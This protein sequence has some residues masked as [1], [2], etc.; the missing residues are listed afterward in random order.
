[1][2]MSCSSAATCS[3]SRSRPERPWSSRHSSNRP[4]REHRDVAAVRAIEPV[5]VPDRLGA[6]QHLVL[7][8]GGA[9]PAA[10][11]GEVEQARRSAATR[12][13]RRA[14]GPS[15]PTAASGRSSRAGT[16]VSAST[17]GR[18]KRS[19]SCS[20]SSRSTE[21]Q[22][23]RN[24]S[25]VTAAHAVGGLAVEDLRRRESHVAADH[26]HVGDPAERDLAANF[27]DDVRDRSLQQRQL[28][29]VGQPPQVELLAQ[30]HGA[31]RVDAGAVGLSLPQQR[32]A[33]AAAADFGEQRPRA[34]AAP[35]CARASAAPRGRPGGSP[36]PR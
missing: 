18:R 33:G 20:S 21:S 12:R 24:A 11:R 29:V 2:P 4:H 23:A 30:P 25:R 15:F 6:G 35:R 31:E 27:V 8:V 9:Q 19:T 28:D 36:R 5:A 32:Q 14:G 3:S 34:R 7:E 10:G 1:M 16:S 13:R 17:A 22:N 26:D